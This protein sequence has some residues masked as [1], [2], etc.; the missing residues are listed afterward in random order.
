MCHI[1]DCIKHKLKTQINGVVSADKLVMSSQV[2]C[3]ELIS[4]IYI[5]L[6]RHS[7]RA[8]ILFNS[9]TPVAFLTM[10]FSA[11]NISTFVFSIFIDN[12]PILPPNI[13]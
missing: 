13:C 5:Y 12:D 3:K 9:C 1:L 7:C 8:E 6:S 10:N 11:A 2:V 4:H